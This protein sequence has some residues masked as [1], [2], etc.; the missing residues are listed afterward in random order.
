MSA[1]DDSTGSDATAVASP[2]I[3][4]PTEREHLPSL[5][6]AANIETVRIPIILTHDATDLKPNDQQSEDTDTGEN[7]GAPLFY[8]GNGP[9]STPRKEHTITLR[10][11]G[12]QRPLS[13][14]NL[15]STPSTNS[16]STRH[17]PTSGSILARGGSP[18]TSVSAQPE[19]GD[20]SSSSF[21]TATSSSSEW[22]SD[23]ESGLPS[24]EAL[25]FGAVGAEAGSLSD[26]LDESNDELENERLLLTSSPPGRR[27][28]VTSG[29]RA[30]LAAFARHETPLPIIN[31]G[32]FNPRLPEEQSE[33]TDFGGDLHFRDREARGHKTRR[34]K[35]NVGK[36]LQDKL[37][38]A[39][40]PVTDLEKDKGFFPLDLLPVLLTEQT[41]AKELRRHLHGI[42][43]PDEIADYSQTICSEKRLS[44]LED[45]GKPKIRTFRKIFAT[46]VL[47][48]K[49]TAI[50][51]FIKQNINDSDLPLVRSQSGP[52]METSREPVR[53]L[54][55]FQEKYGWSQLHIRN[56]EDWQWTT[57]APFFAKSDERKEVRHYP[58]QKRVILPFLSNNKQ[59]EVDSEGGGGRV[60]KA[61]IHEDHHNFHAF[62]S[63]PRGFPSCGSEEPAKC[64]CAFAIKCLHSQDKESFKKEVDMLK[65][66]SNN[67]HAHLISLL[68]TY[69]QNRTFFLV[70]PRAESD[71]LAYWKRTEPPSAADLDGILWV[72][73]QCLGIAK[74]VV[75]IHQYDSSKGRLQVPDMNRIVGNHGD[76]KP[77]NVLWFR[78]T[79]AQGQPGRGTLKLS[80]F[81]LA[82]SN[83]RRTASRQFHSKVAVTCNYR[84]PECDLPNQGGKGRQYDM[85]TIG[86]LYLE[87]IVWL[88]GGYPLLQKFEQARASID[89]GWYNMPTDTFFE[90]VKDE[91]SGQQSAIVK[92]SVKE[93]C[94]ALGREEVLLITLTCATVVHH[95]ATTPRKVHTFHL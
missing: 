84:A 79:D 19:P 25:T 24:R 92:P 83:F 13:R 71:L 50:R 72:A 81:G 32:G 61:V 69:E 66:F 93:V 34:P 17:T 23:A 8:D 87:F 52:G 85:W 41:V 20:G 48:E 49:T 21:F 29:D 30:A 58:L 4:Q 15:P 94:S 64:I 26:I 75:K 63:C 91:K 54:K 47:I 3:I 74:G 55:Y 62:F 56:F 9:T 53:Y 90:L 77:E 31:R 35:P 22:S 46:L 1:T 57:L 59:N 39:L 67:A 28:N 65:R 44:G 78:S 68:A 6:P 37:F 27:Q 2:L 38:K 33:I 73:E 82:E 12:P 51:M 7:A 42:C 86:C 36:S 18:N 45:G 70:F 89:I 11:E 76:I 16:T 10:H 43:G 80:D 88:V 40:E 5:P 14:G 95:D 60:F